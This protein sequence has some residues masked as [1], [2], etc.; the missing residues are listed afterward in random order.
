MPDSAKPLSEA[1]AQVKPRFRPP[2][3]RKT[4]AG[5]YILVDIEPWLRGAVF[6]LPPILSFTTGSVKVTKLRS[7]TE[8]PNI[9]VSLGSIGGK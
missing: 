8:V 1:T 3:G 4:Q 9:V 5:H 6:G 7:V 2:G